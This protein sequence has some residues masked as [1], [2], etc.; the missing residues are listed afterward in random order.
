MN[1]ISRNSIKTLLLGLAP[2]RLLNQSLV[3]LFGLQKKKKKSEDE[4]VDNYDDDQPKCSR[5]VHY[6]YING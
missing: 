4:E 6:L 5:V 3:A 1:R 2:V